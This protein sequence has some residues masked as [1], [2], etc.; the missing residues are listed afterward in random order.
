M[1]WDTYETSYSIPFKSKDDSFIVHCETVTCNNFLV[2]QLEKKFRFS[3]YGNE[4]LII[5]GQLN[6]F[7]T[8][9]TH[10]LINISFVF[11]S[12]QNNAMKSPKNFCLIIIE[13]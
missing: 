5:L 10:L 3:G 7:F 11:L 9:T 2:T 1:H 4:L 6:L 13:A 8:T 12:G